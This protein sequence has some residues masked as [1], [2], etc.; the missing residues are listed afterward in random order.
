M[1]KIKT[2]PGS[3]LISHINSSNIPVTQKNIFNSQFD[4]SGNYII[5]TTDNS[6]AYQTV[7]GYSR[8]CELFPHLTKR[9]QKYT[10]PEIIE[11]VCD[12]KSC[13]FKKQRRGWGCY[14]ITKFL[15]M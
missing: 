15:H 13:L 7:H 9:E 1:T 6:T 8:R 2:I 4:P 3:I 5:F 12:K 11:S 14:I 10:P